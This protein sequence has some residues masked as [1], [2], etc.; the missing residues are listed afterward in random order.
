[1]EQQPFIDLK[2][3]TEFSDEDCRLLQENCNVT[4]KWGD[5]MIRE[6]YDKLLAY[7]PTAT[8]FKEGELSAREQ[9]LRDWYIG[10]CNGK[11]TEA[12]WEQQWLAGL[13]HIR[14]GV[15]SQHV[16]GIM[17]FVQQFFLKHCLEEFEAAKAVAISDAFN[18]VTDVVAGIIVESYRFQ[19]LQAVESTLGV[20]VEL[21]DRMARMG[22]GKAG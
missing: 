12:F 7:H 21:I 6:F 5:Q 20:E 11:L 13:Q 14:R 8:V 3:L 10:V 18:R 9:T 1:M 2:T 19:Y 17:N 16:M 22:A 4:L 15:G